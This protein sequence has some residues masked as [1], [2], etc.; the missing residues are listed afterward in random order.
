MFSRARSAIAVGGP[1]T[2]TITA[3]NS[4]GSAT[5]TFT[6]TVVGSPPSFSDGSTFSGTFYA[7]YSNTCTI[8]AK[9]SPTPTYALA[10]GSTLPDNVSLS[11][12]GSLT[13]TSAIAAGGPYTFTITATNSQGSTSQTITLT[14][15]T[16]SKG[17]GGF[18]GGGANLTDGTGSGSNG[19]T[20][21]DGTG[22]SGLGG[23]S[24]PQGGGAIE[25]AGGTLVVTGCV[26][27][28]T[29]GGGNSA[30]GS[31]NEG[32]GAV[33]VG[34][35]SPSFTNCTFYLNTSNAPGGAVNVAG[36][37]TSPVFTNCQFTG[38]STIGTGAGIN[39][40]A[41]AVASGTPVF[42]QCTFNGNQ[43]TGTGG[44]VEVDGGTLT[45]TNCNFLAGNSSGSSGSAIYT[46]ANAV[47]ENTTIT[48]CS[49][50]VSGAGIYA[51]GNL[52]ILN[53]Y[54]TGNQAPV[55]AAL[56]VNT[57]VATILNT[58]FDGNT[59]GT[60]GGA[61]YSAGSDLTIVNDTITSNSAGTGAGVEMDAASQVILL[62]DIIA[63]NSGTNPDIDNSSAGSL[64]VNN[65]MIG[66]ASGNSITD[67]TN[68]NIV[69]PSSTGLTSLAQNGVSPYP[70]AQGSTLPN[71][72]NGSND[73]TYDQSI[74]LSPASAG[75]GSGA[76]I[77]TLSTAVSAGATT[78]VL[79][80]SS[81]FA[82]SNL[83][84]LPPLSGQSTA[85]PYF[86]LEFVSASG[87]ASDP[88]QVESIS[89]NTLTL[90][91]GTLAAH[92][93][94]DSI[95]LISDEV[96]ETTNNPVYPNMGALEISN[97][98][99]TYLVFTTEPPGTPINENT[100]FTVAVTAYNPAG[101]VATAYGFPVTLTLSS[102]GTTYG[103]VAAVN[104][105]VTFSTV[106]VAT[107]GTYTLTASGAR[108]D[109]RLQQ[110]Y[111]HSSHRVARLH[112]G[113][114]LG[115]PR[116]VCRWDDLQ[117]DRGGGNLGRRVGGRRR[118]RHSLHPWNADRSPRL[119]HAYCLHR[120]ADRHRHDQ[121]HHGHD[122][123][124]RHVYV[125]RVVCR[126]GGQQLHPG[127]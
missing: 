27:G 80:N 127:G 118:R 96:H 95:N 52:T 64:T 9:G 2:F 12:S 112:P 98:A 38:N 67:G 76:S 93:A 47:V 90:V 62:N 22:S 41:V 45:I 7:G 84:A 63:G 25:V 59:A 39:G 56:Y 74:Q 100:A 72:V 1:Y 92:A 108:T 53:S 16:K 117:H 42:T 66:D 19:V 32:G 36:S 83:S 71:P 6:L 11:P 122:R 115:T 43:T 82:A 105:V 58:T 78:I 101:A 116:L 61:I 37:G 73:Q 123:F 33:Y 97:V 69:A 46:N 55:G 81:G 24:G 68:G 126:S 20:L 18:G 94:G 85:A 119:G 103:P 21:T 14:V 120:L 57:G 29:A 13:S 35:G 113:A 8:A 77:T 30:I 65:S 5:Q 110:L 70:L 17:G 4:Q 31:N 3:T 109:R 114:G 99:A 34:G 28:T 124:E 106:S 125:Q 48:G 121:H 86:T 88:V 107:P 79:A 50:S 23:T 89:G 75:V 40:G 104:G 15:S 51:T 87:V 10:S 26:F 49:A 44:A 60:S 54:F 111:H 91:S 102:G